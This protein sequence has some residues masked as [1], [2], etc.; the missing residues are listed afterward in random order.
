MKKNILILLLFSPL[1][2]LAQ[3][4]AEVKD[5]TSLTSKQI[6]KE[7]P[8]FIEVSFGINSSK[9]RDFATSPL[10]YSAKTKMFSVGFLRIDE[11]RESNLY[12]KYSSGNYKIDNEKE[13][14]KSSVS[15]IFIG[16]SR[17]QRL[18]K[19]S[20]EKWNYKVGGRIDLTGNLRDNPSLQNN[21][22]GV[23]FFNT[24]FISGKVTRNVS[25]KVN[26]DKKFLFVKY[27]RKPRKMWLSYRLDV[28]L[29][30]NTF[31][32]G[33]IYS[34]VSST[35]ND[36]KMFS[37]YELNLFSGFRIAAALDH[38][39]E[40]KNGSQIRFSYLW[41]TY[42]TGGVYDKFVMSHH[43]LQASFLFNF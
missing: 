23:E 19:W 41:D 15:S 17:L 22:A 14:S 11:V 7:R 33:Y 9:F 18:N 31:R 37:D 2:L 32:N 40:I 25:R 42:T 1:M 29:M 12:A 21:A 28:S 5:S 6:R 10:T 36:P 20:T 3:E 39:I 27:K 43:V 26:K 4:N 35:E 34:N 16:Y 38:T 24:L 13:P 30:N 8:R